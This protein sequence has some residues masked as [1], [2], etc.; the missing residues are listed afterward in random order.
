MQC[1]RRRALKLHKLDLTKKHTAVPSRAP[2]RGV[3]ISR[4]LERLRARPVPTTCQWRLYRPSGPHGS[5]LL[6]HRRPLPHL[7]HHLQIVK[8]WQ[9]LVW[10]LPRRRAVK[11]R[12]VRR[13]QYKGATKTDALIRAKH[14][15][16]NHLRVVS[17]PSH[18][19]CGERSARYRRLTPEVLGAGKQLHQDQQGRRDGPS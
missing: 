13:K 16:T 11:R 7:L 10:P 5:P 15:K 18:R 12:R 1:A 4:S 19:P 6:L 14:R 9:Q 3:R 2:W 8:R 17:R